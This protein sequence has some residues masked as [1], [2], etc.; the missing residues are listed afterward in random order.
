MCST[1]H[2]LAFSGE[3]FQPELQVDTISTR[4]LPLP[5][6][7]FSNALRMAFLALR[8]AGTLYTL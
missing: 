2:W 7:L 6:R 5:A 1:I 4:L 3:S 8:M